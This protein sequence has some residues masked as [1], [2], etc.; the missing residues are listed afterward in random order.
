MSDSQLTSNVG[1]QI[2]NST[3]MLGSP[4]HDIRTVAL[5]LERV[6]QDQAAKDGWMS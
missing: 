1:G 4:K 2:K 3:S 6:T 5:S